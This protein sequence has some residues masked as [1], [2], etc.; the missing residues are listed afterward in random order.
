MKKYFFLLVAFVF[1]GSVVSGQKIKDALYLKNGSVIYG[2][3]TEVND[4]QYKIKTKDGSLFS[5]PA[6]EVDKFIKE[7]PA[8]DGRKTNGVGFALEAGCLAG[9]KSSNYVAPF[10]FNFL[11]NVT[12][13]TRHII[14]LGT[15][16]EF[17]GRSYMPFFL[18]YKYILYN[19]MATPFFFTRVG[20]LCNVGDSEGNQVINRIHTYYNGGFSTAFGTGISWARD[21]YERYLSF[22]YRYFK[23]SRTESDSN[24]YETDYTD[25]YNRLEIKFG[26]RF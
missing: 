11:G 13:K 7:N 1:A 18:E 3:L 14:G 17:I 26:W 10:S 21:N 24:G 8:F 12:L 25:N 6:Q 22:A 23:T 5:Y 20:G 9:S 2:V 19:D 16:V 4:N 15:G